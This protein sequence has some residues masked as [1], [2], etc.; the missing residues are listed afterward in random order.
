M[1]IIVDRYLS[2]AE[3]TLSRVSVYD[4]VTRIFRCYGLEDEFREEKV[5]SETR[6][7][8]GRYTVGV[9]TEGGFHG[10][11]SKDRRF[12]DFHRG[13][14]HV[15][16]VPG[17]EFILIHVGN[18]EKD[19]AGC[20]LVGETRSEHLFEIYRSSPAY[21]KLYKAVIDA[22]ERGDLTIEYQDNDRK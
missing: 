21:R 17:F 4:G 14:L 16:D 7:P 19:T 11:Y 12:R 5:H 6:I 20:L 8:A 9:R 22:A 1:K 13:M 10:R 3:A 2:N 18:Y 15:L